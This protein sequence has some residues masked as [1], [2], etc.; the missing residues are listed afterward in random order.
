VGLT[1]QV[2]SGVFGIILYIE[3]GHSRGFCGQVFQVLVPKAHCV[4]GRR[5]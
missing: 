3:L 1:I 4:I 2:V 5:T